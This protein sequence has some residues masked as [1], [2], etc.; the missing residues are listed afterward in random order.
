MKKKLTTDL[1]HGT[2]IRR[3]SSS[4]GLW[5]LCSD[6]NSYKVY[7]NFGCIVMNVIYISWFV[8]AKC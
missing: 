6:V 3:G 2:S 1:Y 7:R 4:H 5:W 8:I